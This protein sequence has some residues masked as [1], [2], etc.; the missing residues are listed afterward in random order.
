MNQIIP[1]RPERKAFAARRLALLASA[2]GLAIAVVAGPL[3]ASTGRI[4]QLQAPAHAETM[5]RSTG[6]A[7]IVEKVKPAVISVRVKVDATAKMTS[8][9]EGDGDATQAPRSK[10]SSSSLAAAACQRDTRR[11]SAA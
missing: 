6:F 4:F 2:A 11:A 5:Q 10:S 8:M 9:S 7:D 3:Q 1:A